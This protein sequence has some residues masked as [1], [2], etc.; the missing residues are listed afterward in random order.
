MLEARGTTPKSQCTASMLKSM[1][2]ESLCSLP[3][4]AF[5][6]K[7]HTSVDRS[8]RRYVNSILTEVNITTVSSAKPH[9]IGCSTE[10]FLAGWRCEL[11][12][13]TN[14]HLPRTVFITPDGKVRRFFMLGSVALCGENN[15]DNSFSHSF[16]LPVVLDPIPSTRSCWALAGTNRSSESL[17]S[18]S[19][20]MCP[21][22]S[23]APR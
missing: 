11:S 1:L 10:S 16:R 14:S 7:Y 13:D 15:I 5:T 17:A 9:L 2:H 20:E 8:L 21:G 4:L 23:I 18:I 12:S 3:R 22:C 19:Y 6:A